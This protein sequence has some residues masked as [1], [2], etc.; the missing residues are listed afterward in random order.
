MRWGEF[1]TL[2]LL[3]NGEDLN[4]L[5]CKRESHISDTGKKEKKRESHKKW[6]LMW[7]SVFICFLIPIMILEDLFP[8]FN[9]GSFDIFCVVLDDPF[10]YIKVIQ[11]FLS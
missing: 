10:I 6:E 11:I 4:L 9:Q 8:T 3:K 7:V 5:I 2:N 1:D